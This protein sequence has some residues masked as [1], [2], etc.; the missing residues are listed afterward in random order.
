M[1]DQGAVSAQFLHKNPIAQPLRSAQITVV[2]GE[3]Q[4]KGAVVVCHSCFFLPRSGLV[5]EPGCPQSNCGRPV[6]AVP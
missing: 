5:L 3:S 6:W 2:T 4:D 1:V